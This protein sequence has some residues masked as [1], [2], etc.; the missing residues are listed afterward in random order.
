MR[1]PD[2]LMR[3]WFTLLTDRPLEEII[4]LSDVQ[5]TNPRQAKERLGMD[6]VSFYHGEA[7]AQAAAEDFIRQFR[8]K[9]DPADITERKIPLSD[10]SDGRMP[11]AKLLTALELAKSGNEARRL[12]QQGGVSLGP[13]R[14][15]VTD[16]NL[17]VPVTAGL[18]VRVGRKVVRVVLF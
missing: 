8:C 10:L 4:R 7:A 18:V 2:H 11:I 1:I 3:E 15:K 14:D 5:L 16:G 9:E 13:D 17:A 12:I 6:I